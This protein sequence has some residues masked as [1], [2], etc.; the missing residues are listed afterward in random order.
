M[1]HF[2]FQKKKK[3]KNDSHKKNFKKIKKTLRLRKK[4]ETP[5]RTLSLFSFKKGPHVR[6]FFLND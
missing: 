1:T 4:R 2:R 6:N 5:I 3:K